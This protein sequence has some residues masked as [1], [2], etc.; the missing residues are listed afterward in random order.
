MSTFYLMPPRPV[1]EDSLAQFLQTWLPGLAVPA[2]AGADVT[3]LLQSDLERRAI[4][5]LVFREDL[6]DD[7]E[8]TDALRDGFG[9]EAGDR[10]IEM[11]LAGRS[12]EVVARSWTVGGVSAT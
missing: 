5:F 10:V 4:A 7:A 1:F 12:G 3:D 2:R 9:A 11:H 6:P 8:P